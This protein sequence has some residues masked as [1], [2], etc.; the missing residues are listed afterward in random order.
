MKF[1]IALIILLFTSS[2][3]LS[4]K[5]SKR[6]D[7]NWTLIWNNDSTFFGYEDKNGVVKIEPE[8]LGLGCNRSIIFENIVPV[9]VSSVEGSSYYIT[10]SGNIVG[11]DSVYF[12]DSCF[13]CESEGFIR[14]KDSKTRNDGLLNKHGKVAIPAEYNT[15]SKVRNGMLIGVKG[16]T[17]EREGEYTLL[18]GGTAYLIDTLNNILVKGIEYRYQTN[19]YSLEIT[20]NETIDTTKIS[21]LGING[22]YYT[23]TNSE[24]EFEQWFFSSLL[25]E[26]SIENLLESTYDTLLWNN[27]KYHKDYIINSRFK[28]LE[29][30]LREILVLNY[31]Y[32]IY[33]KNYEFHRYE[34]QEFEKYR[35]NCDEHKSEQFPLFRFVKRSSGIFD[36]TKEVLDFL[37]TENGYKLISV[38]FFDEDETE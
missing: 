17:L 35:N 15:L 33:K 14:F 29:S 25:N 24:K 36:N 7:D 19:L 37:R 23:F 18:K 3:S 12:F 16:A 38:R 5:G 9:F 30:E 6:N 20:E 26:I 10:K 28:Q 1:V 4:E 27:T 32:S 31:D 2:C 13:D 21:Y 34:Y 8:L 22:Q 11:K